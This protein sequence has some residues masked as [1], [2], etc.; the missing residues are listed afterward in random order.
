MTKETERRMKGR[1]E[2]V[3]LMDG[4]VRHLNDEERIVSRWFALGVEDH[5]PEFTDEDWLAYC[6]DE[7]YAEIC[8]EFCSL[9]ADVMEEDGIDG[10]TFV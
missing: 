10:S 4:L 6:E 9:M 8:G 2:V 5:G 7:I 1:L 3:K